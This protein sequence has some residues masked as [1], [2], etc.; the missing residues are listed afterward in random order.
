MKRLY[1]DLTSLREAVAFFT[2]EPD[3]EIVPAGT[4]VYSMSAK[5]RN[6][7]YQMYA[8]RYGLHFIFDDSLPEVDFYTV[9][10][11]ELFA[12]DRRGGLLGTILGSPDLE[13]E[14]PVCYISPERKLYRAAGSLAELLELAKG[15]GG[16]KSNLKEEHSVSLYASREQAARQLDFYSLPGDLL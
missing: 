8:D 12:S 7:V 16:W 10:H 13:E 6:A 11:V 4:T 9:P 5:D 15:P 14:R 2:S 1:I 3:T